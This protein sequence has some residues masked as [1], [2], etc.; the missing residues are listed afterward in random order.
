MSFR[1]GVVVAT[2]P[3]DHS[4]DLVMLDDGM[5]LVGVQVL[6]PNGS[7]RT[8]TVHMT[9]VTRE[10]D[11]WDASKI[12]DQDQIA[13]V[14]YVRGNP[15]VVGFLFPQINQM[16]FKDPS[17][18]LFRHPSDVMVTVDGKGNTQI[19]HPSGAAIRIGDSAEVANPAGTNFD[20]NLAVTRNMEVP[21]Y[22]HVELAGGQVSMTL[23]PLGEVT[24]KAPI[25]IRLDT[26]LVSV[27][28]DVV[29]DAGVSLNTHLHTGV[30][31]GP[32]L[33]GPPST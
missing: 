20:E 17:T 10:G 13:I 1:Q 18:F 26:P 14:G 24:V 5:R 16:T 9:P 33:T 3:E 19:L 6:T 22:V 15:I 2:H 27:S 11:K 32:S 7:A 31:P 4:V 28:G 12:T 21:A 23:S 8:G 29:T 25:K 30:L